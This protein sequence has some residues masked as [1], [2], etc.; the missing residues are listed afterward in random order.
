MYAA[1]AVESE[2][3]LR[4]YTI[5]PSCQR[6]VEMKSRQQHVA[7]CMCCLSIYRSFQ[8][9]RCCPRTFERNAKALNSI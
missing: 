7:V 6:G 9:N 4:I 8:F 1:V 3:K 5:N 2:A